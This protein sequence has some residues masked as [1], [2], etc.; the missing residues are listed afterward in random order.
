MT[1]RN[2]ALCS[3]LVLL[4]VSPAFAQRAVPPYDL[5]NSQL[6]AD[7]RNQATLQPQISSLGSLFVSSYDV[8]FTSNP[9]AKFFDAAPPYA[10][11][12]GEKI[13]IHAYLAVP[14]FPG[15]Y[16]AL[17]IGHGHGGSADLSLA[18]SVAALGYV[19]LAIDGPQAGKSTGGPR[20]D[21]QAWISVDK[22]P[23]YGYLYHYA[24][25]GMRALTLLQ[26]LAGQ[27]GNPYRIDA[28]KLGVFGASMGGIFTTYIN[29]IDDRVK[30]AI[31]ISCAGNWQHS[32][33]DPNGWLYHGLYT[34]TRDLPYNGSDPLNSIENVDTDS[35]AV[36][37]FDYF[38]PV[39]YG[40]RQ[41]APVL[42]VIGTHD[43]Y[44][45]LPNAN[46]MQQAITSAGVQPNFEKRLWVL[47]NAMHGLS[48]TSSSETVSLSDLAAIV[49]VL[50]QW[51]N[52]CFG[53][54]DRPLATPQISLSDAGNGLRFEVALSGPAARLAKAG[55]KLYVAT[56]INS[57]VTPVQDF[58]E[59]AASLQNDRFVVQLNKGEKSS[60]G[61]AFTGDNVIYFSTATDS[62]GLKVSSLVYK[63]S[64]PIDLSTDFMPTI[65]QYPGDKVV[66]PVPP[67]YTPAATTLASSISLNG[68]A[69][70]QGMA[71]TNPTSDAMAVR[72]DA[73]TAD[74]RL[75]SA[76]GLINP[77]FMTLPPLS[78]RVFVAEEWLGPGARRL[79]GSLRMSWSDARATALAF[80]GNEG[81][82]EL[83]AIGPLNLSRTPLWLPLAPDL[84]PGANRHLRIF[85]EAASAS[86]DVTVTFYD[87]AGKAVGTQTVTIAASGT[88]EIPL[89]AGSGSSSAAYARIDSGVSV[90]AR[91]EA[92]ANRDPWSIEAR[93]APA[94]S[95][96]LIQPHVEWNGVFG[97]RLLVLNTASSPQTLTLRLHAAD[98]SAA[99][100]DTTRTV[101]A[102]AVLS[103]TVESIFGIAAGAASGAGW[104]EFQSDG[105]GVLA[106]AFAADPLTGA[107]A[108]SPIGTGAAGSWSMPYFVSGSGYW[109]GLAL[110]NSVTGTAS[111]RIIAYDAAGNTMGQVSDSLAPGSRRTMLV[112]QWIQNLPAD[113]TGQIIIT[114]SAP[115]SLLAYFGTNDG[116]TLAAIPFTAISP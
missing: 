17:V 39:R 27:A 43:G 108:A 107:A 45:P 50:R 95:A 16:P 7:I 47:P 8:Y 99:A 81:P 104:F 110:A 9:S 109:T 31:I 36:T 56:R 33:R 79:D 24:Y 49:D 93:P 106:T 87:A 78:Q 22:G 86:A 76:E 41:Y 61:D 111:F 13:T 58:K 82:S 69:D 71:L 64:I 73:W 63:G 94:S 114:S 105:A 59:Y 80:R 52:Y 4:L 30:A 46:L 75:D 29:G 72:V 34:G 55:V 23:E 12:V 83:E 90:A 54:P 28:S 42:T 85:T 101:A 25:A 91:I 57:T 21:N 40:A 62:V 74:G 100:P 116:A 70:Y 10:E 113:A 26:S 67:A 89:P 11:H 6:L 88:A 32:L 35:T 84:D 96:R 97:T 37:F 5:W 98:G 48:T 115:L 20:D 14:L 1:P 66:A 92:A 68:G 53:A 44:F 3:A 2:A 19:A 112:S 77:V 51:L 38:D 15:T 103:E 65:D 18:Q 102:G 60:S